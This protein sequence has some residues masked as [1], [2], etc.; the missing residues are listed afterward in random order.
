DA[1]KI[2]QAVGVKD[3]QGQIVDMRTVI[4]NKEFA[5][6][7][8]KTGIEEDVDKKVWAKGLTGGE[9]LIDSNLSDNENLRR[10]V[11]ATSKLPPTGEES[12]TQEDPV[13]N[14]Q[15]SYKPPVPEFTETS[16]EYAQRL[17]QNDNFFDSTLQAEAQGGVVAGISS[18]DIEMDETVATLTA[19]QKGKGV[20]RRDDH[21]AS[22]IVNESQLLEFSQHPQA[23]SHDTIMNESSKKFETLE[24][25]DTIQTDT[26]LE[27]QVSA[28]QR[29]EEKGAAQEESPAV[30][31][32]ASRLA[33][34]DEACEC[35]DSTEIGVMV[36]CTSCESWRHNA[37][38]GYPESEDELPEIFTCYRCR[39][40]DAA[41][42]ALLDDSRAGDIQHALANLKS[43]ALFRRAISL[44][45]TIGVVDSRGL[46]ENLKIDKATAAQV[47]K[48]LQ[49]EKF[50]I[51]KQTLSKRR[52]KEVKNVS[53]K[54]ES[55]VNRSAEQTKKKDSEYFSPGQGA[56]K[57]ILA[58]LTAS[59]N[60]D[61]NDYANIQTTSIPTH[62]P[63]VLVPDTPSPATIAAS[64]V[65]AS[66]V[67]HSNRFD[68]NK[69]LQTLEEER[70][71]NYDGSSDLSD[72]SD[73]EE[74]AQGDSDRL[75]QKSSTKFEMNST[76][77][78]GPSFPP[79]RTIPVAPQKPNMV[80]GT[81]SASPSA[82][83]EEQMQIDSADQDLATPRA[84]TVNSSADRP[85]SSQPSASAIGQ[86]PKNE[87]KH[88]PAASMPSIPS[89]RPASPDKEDE[90]A[91]FVATQN[92][93]GGG[94]EWRKV[95][96]QKVSESEENLEAE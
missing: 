18:E 29:R 82:S 59:D 69:T 52:S 50:I 51:P 28:N 36:C 85:S 37:C 75:A 55:I 90:E 61:N 43:L 3:D 57:P 4:R 79:R 1:M 23:E 22:P 83:T 15:H 17:A 38:Y 11:A 47:L 67:S 64:P 60:E 84:Q 21:F 62:T 81:S 10:A 73:L 96:K 80:V 27:P 12:V 88:L 53:K 68:R 71:D 25:P 24:E 74:Q 16:D 94:T 65:Q 48:R 41:E 95:K 72:L 33:T 2:P 89:K 39:A 76:P 46:G 7:R 26:Q 58:M 86:S 13:V 5:G 44:I 91:E 34:E 31:R 49:N 9:D 92:G 54:P 45:W 40:H 77:R 6:L 63:R 87:L 42:D 35:G 19:D 78:D 14:R 32:S 70:E 20:V 56:E 30:K 8:K 66:S 93:K